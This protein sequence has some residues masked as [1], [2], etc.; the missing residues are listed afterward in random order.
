MPIQGYKVWRNP[1]HPYEHPHY[2]GELSPADGV[3]R[4]SATDLV[5][6]G[7]PQAAIPF[8]YRTGSVRSTH[9]GDGNESISDDYQ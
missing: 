8:G 9:W 1:R 7:L 6:L 3:I 4:L 2:I 5:K